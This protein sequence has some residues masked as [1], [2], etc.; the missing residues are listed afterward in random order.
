MTFLPTPSDTGN[1]A[2][3]SDNGVMRS[4]PPPWIENVPSE[5]LVSS[6]AYSPS[7]M[8]RLK[9][10]VASAPT[11]DVC[12]L[13]VGSSMLALSA[14]TDSSAEH[15]NVRG[16]SESTRAKDDKRI[17]WGGVVS[18]WTRALRCIL[19]VLERRVRSF[20]L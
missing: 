13:S 18:G 16:T 14:M 20:A 9:P 4:T 2:P 3:D 7:S 10:P 6:D 11:L 8:A 19:L 15:A 12:T 5:T 1:V 17:D